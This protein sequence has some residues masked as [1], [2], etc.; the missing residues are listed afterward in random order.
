MDHQKEAI[1]LLGSGKILYGGVGTGKTITAQ[2]TVI[3]AFV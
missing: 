3:A 1:A 2:S